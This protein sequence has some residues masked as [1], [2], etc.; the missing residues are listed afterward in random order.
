MKKNFKSLFL[1]AAG[2]L[3]GTQVWAL[4]QSDGIYQIGT[5]QD[6]AD[7]ATLVN[8]GDA[9]ANA[10]LTADIDLTGVEMAPIGTSDVKYTGTFDGQGH[11]VSNFK[12]ETSQENAG[13]FGYIEGATVQNLSIGGELTSS[14]GNI[15]T[16]AYADGDALI[17]HVESSMAIIAQKD[18]HLGGVVGSLRKATVEYSTF[19]GSIESIGFGDAMGGITGYTNNGLIRYCVNLGK[20]HTTKGS[21]KAGGI[22]G[23]VNNGSFQGVYGCLNTGTI[24]ID[25]IKDYEAAIVGMVNTSTPASTVHD[26]VWLEGSSSKGTG[27]PVATPSFCATSEMLSNGEACWNLNGDQTDIRWC[28]NI[29]VD[30]LPNWNSKAIVYRNGKQNCDGSDAGISFSNE[31]LG[32]ERAKHQID[33]EGF[34]TVCGNLD[35]AEDGYY[36]VP[37]AKALRWVAEQ[38]N[39]NTNRGISFRLTAD[40]DLSDGDW[41]P[42]GNDNVMFSGNMDGGRHKISHMTVNGETATG[43]FG[44]VEKADI[45]DLIIDE[46][47]SVTGVKYTGGLIGHSSSGNKVNITGVG[48]LCDVIG[49]GEAAAGIIGNANSGSICNISKCWT[50]GKISAGKDAACLSGWEGNV[51][52]VIQNCWS[53]SEVTGYQDEAHYMAR[54]GGL[55]LKNCYCSFGTQ[56]DHADISNDMLTTGELCYKVNGLQENIIWYQNLG[57][58]ADICPVPWSDHG[59]VYA[60]GELRC[61]GTSLGSVNYANEKISEIPDHQLEGGFCTVCGYFVENYKTAEDGFFML[62]NA[63][64]LCWFSAYVDKVSKSASAKLTDDVDMAGFMD[65]FIPLGGTVGYTGTFDGQGHTISNFVL[66]TTSNDAGFVSVAA[67]GMHIQNLIMD[68]T[69]SVSTTMNYAGGFVGGTLSGVTTEIY[70]TNLGFEGTVFTGGVNAGAIV[71]CN[72]GSSALFIMRNCYSTGQIVGEGGESGALSGWIGSKGGEVSGC[73][74]TSEVT[75][76][77]SENKYLF[78]YSGSPNAF[79]NYSLYGK[80]GL[81]LDESELNTGALTWKLNGESFVDAQWFQTLG[82]DEHPVFDSTHGLVYNTGEESYACVTDE[83]SFLELRSSIIGDAQNRREE[84]VACQSLLDEYAA[85]FENNLSSCETLDAFLEAY[86]NIQPLEEQVSASEQIYAQYIATVE[87]V[88]QYLEENQFGGAPREFLENYLNEE[89]EPD[90]SYSN[91]SYPYISTTHL[92]TDEEVAQEMVFLNNML[93]EAIASDYQPGS[94]ITNLLTNPTLADGF[95]GWEYSYNGGTMWTDGAEGKLPAAENWNC[96]FDLR[97][98]LT[99]LKDGIYVL[100]LNAAFRPGA[101]LYSQFYSAMMYLNDNVNYVMAEADDVLLLDAAIDGENC[102][103]SGDAADYAYVYGEMEG[104]VPQGP[105]GC[106]YAFSAGRYQNSSLVEVKDGVLTVGLKNPGTGL[107]RDWTGYGNFRLFYLGTAEQAGVALDEALAGYVQRAQTTLDFVWSQDVDYAQYPNISQSLRDQLQEAI[108]EAQSDLSAEQKVALAGTF[109]TLFQQI[110]DC[111]QA[112]VAMANAAESVNSIS[113]LLADNGYIEAD[114][115]AAEQMKADEAWEGYSEGTLSAE[116]ALQMAQGLLENELYPQ[117]ENGVYQIETPAHLVLFSMIVNNGNSSAKAVL[118]G[119]IDMKGGTMD[120]IG[121]DGTPF[122]GSFDG[123]GHRIMNL[124]INLPTVNSVGL[125]GVIASPAEISNFVLDEGCTIIGVEKAGII[126][127]SDGGGIVYLTNLGNEGTV[128]ADRAAAGILGNANNGSIAY[129]T[130]CYSTGKIT[131]ITEGKSNVDNSLIC[132]WLGNVGALVTDCWSCAE[133]TGY[134][135]LER[136]FCRLGGSVTFTNCYSTFGTEVNVITTDQV[137]SGELCYNLNSANAENPFWFQTI[138]SDLHPVLDSR[139]SV[140]YLKD[141]VYYNDEN[142]IHEIRQDG[143]ASKK[144]IFDLSGRRVVNP[145]RG[146]YIVDGKLVI[147]K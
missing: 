4:D 21:C 115:A 13:F 145:Q 29:G 117:M 123:Q 122:T 18:T 36:L 28:Q 34:C 108:D 142:A 126:G 144:G 26:N 69:C 89:F 1:L 96:T 48:V 60:N 98:T 94:E 53:T 43:F 135:S 76:Y 46:T 113:Q 121:K 58:N 131:T 75:N 138:G 14:G 80:Q 22:L 25:G 81:P 20:V 111:R 59:Q 62:D 30:E 146:I 44:T 124:S 93:N 50:T 82:T 85:A 104:Y 92:L 32:F 107:D 119:D 23:Y 134:Q 51:G 140:V 90:D 127:K 52:A 55:T 24:Q 78:R 33:A 47:C 54:Y 109:S 118:T 87:S 31:N 19:S 84:S 56:C 65:R 57:E 40:I 11:S 88:I 100:K 120:P 67:A 147:L 9:G 99:D 49:S 70:F 143:T 38:V 72:H 15:G 101:N 132:G 110:Y 39:T 2:C 102:H 97:Q 64:D 129:I 8:N 141:G 77:Q 35:Q 116:E 37:T 133:I 86:R 103:I 105:L 79:N 83:N 5:P 68:K 3:M 139:S 61:D 74:S 114:M 95:N 42:I 12:L 130:R 45:C 91:G 73:W 27:G 6:L 137:A 41:T 10:V 63:Q 128:I 16:I 71:G 66:E 136:C 7:F 106:S 125:F 17:S 112:Y